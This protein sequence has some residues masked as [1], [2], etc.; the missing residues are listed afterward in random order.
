[1]L[2]MIDEDTGYQMKQ[3]VET[4]K[5]I[6]VVDDEPETL[7]LV[8]HILQ[9]EPGYIVYKASSGEEAL[10]ILKDITVELIL[11]DVQMPGMDG[12]GVCEEIRKT[13]DVPIVFM[14][15]DKN[16]ETIEK[17]AKMGIKDDLAK[18]VTALPLLEVIRSIL[19]DEGEY[20]L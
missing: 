19:Q 6:L 14:M 20:K 4:T 13:S 1:M 15:D 3:R 18:P 11:L 8:A 9:D 12:F 5:H 17:A 2:C 7:D 16:F 10:E